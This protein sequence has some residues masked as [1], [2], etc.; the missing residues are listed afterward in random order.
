[1]KVELMQDLKML[2]DL[3]QQGLLPQTWAEGCVVLVGTGW[4]G[5]VLIPNRFPL[6]QL[7]LWLT[8][9]A[10]WS[11]FLFLILLSLPPFQLSFLSYLCFKPSPPPAFW[12]F[13]LHFSPL[14]FF[15]TPVSP[16]WP[17]PLCISTLVFHFSLLCPLSVLASSAPFWVNWSWLLA[18]TIQNPQPNRSQGIP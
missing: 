14:A 2:V 16:A 12:L 15:S 3:P 18:L 10:F 17:F 13:Y 4:I 6:L 11:G 9:S 1:M 5:T 7:C 8:S